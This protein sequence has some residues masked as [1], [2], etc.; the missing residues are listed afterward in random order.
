M[1]EGCF[2]YSFN[3]KSPYNVNTYFVKF[4]CLSQRNFLTHDEK[5]KKNN[6]TSFILFIFFVHSH[7]CLAH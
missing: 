7:V 5:N 1:Y 2:T 6:F 4:T 3:S